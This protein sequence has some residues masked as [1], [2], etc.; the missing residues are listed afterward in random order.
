MK[1]CL[2]ALVAAFGS[3]VAGDVK[4]G[5]PT[6]GSATDNCQGALPSFEGKL[7]KRPL[8]INNEGT[9]PAF[10]SCGLRAP[11]S[12]EKI[13]AI[14][15]LFTNRGSATATVN[16][17][18][19]EGVALPFPGYPPVYLPKSVAIVAGEAAVMQWE[20]AD[21]GGSHYE[22]PNLSCGLPPGT[23]INVL[24]TSTS[25]VPPA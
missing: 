23:E 13:E 25:V 20:L 16:C 17:T 1:V 9:S 4:A 6:W 15:V 19:V 7:R 21:N 12:G 22:I 8:G 10:V 3:V 5:E 14:Y 11:L 2:L 24:Q 18:L